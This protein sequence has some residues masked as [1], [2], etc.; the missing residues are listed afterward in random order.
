MKAYK[1]EVLIVDHEGYGPDN[2]RVVIEQHRHL[3]IARVLDV[4]EADIGKWSDDH[5]LNS[6]KTMKA[7]YDRLFGTDHITNQTT[8]S[9]EIV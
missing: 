5:P 4:K 2:F 3:S 7:E 6:K 8:I 1:F 9:K